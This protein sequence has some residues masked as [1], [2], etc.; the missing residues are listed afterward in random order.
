MRMTDLVIEVLDARVPRSSC[1]PTFETL[2][3]AG[4]KPALKLLN[5]SDLADPEQTRLWLQH[6]NAQPGVQ[7]L[8]L[9]AKKVERGR[10]ASCGLSRA[11]TRPRQARQAA[12]H[13]DPRHPQRGEVHTHERA[14]QAPRRESRRRA[15][16]HQDADVPQA[17]P[18]HDARRHARDD[19]ARDGQDTASSSP[20]PTASGGRRTTTKRWPSASVSRC[21][22]VI[23]SSSRRGSV[24]FPGPATS[25]ACWRSS[26]PADTSSRPEGRTLP[27]PRRPS[28]R[29]FRSGGR[30]RRKLEPRTVRG[31]NEPRCSPHGLSTR[32]NLA[33]NE[34]D[35]RG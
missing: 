26:P 24:D 7:G 12:A 28:S 13:D 25:T 27:A 15:G 30:A 3:R 32:Y 22:D 33:V 18:G 8:A 19:V 14:P 20:R 5:K 21:C 23:P 11:A 2:R 16:H 34:N 10:F 6:Y 31:R 1:N 9:S 17:R 35:G 4:Q 29:D